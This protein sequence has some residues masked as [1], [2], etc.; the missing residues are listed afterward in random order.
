VSANSRDLEALP[1]AIIS[2]FLRRRLH[3]DDFL[4][5]V[6]VFKQDEQGLSIFC[7]GGFWREVIRR[8]FLHNM[9]MGFGLALRW[10]GN[11][12]CNEFRR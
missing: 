1:Q 11:G 12:T 5:F 3:C 10:A 8:K 9:M 2:W 6:S 4:P 7:M